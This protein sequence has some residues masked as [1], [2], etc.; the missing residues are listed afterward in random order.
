MTHLSRTIRETCHKLERIC[1]TRCFSI[2]LL[3][4]LLTKSDSLYK[5]TTID[6]RNAKLLKYEYITSMLQM[7]H[8]SGRKIR[9]LSLQADERCSCRLS[10]D[11]IKHLMYK[12]FR[13]LKTLDISGNKL[14]HASKLFDRNGLSNL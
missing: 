11:I 7:L 8:L 6:L 14:V 1:F 10:D 13:D 12:S 9:N 3:W 5:L 4:D 2:H